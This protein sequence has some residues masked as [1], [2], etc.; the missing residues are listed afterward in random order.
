M[1]R[2]ERGQAIIEFAIVLPM[3]FLLIFGSIDIYFALIAKGT[4]NYVAEET[5]VCV[6][7][8][9]AACPDPQAYAE[10]IGG[11]LGLNGGALQVTQTS[12]GPKSNT[13]T[14]V[15]RYSAVTKFIPSITMTAVAT[16][17]Q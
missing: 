13:I 17:T 10:Q 16:A 1:K 11:G 6:S 8:N 12:S 3:F 4:L 14:A 9:P 2:G 15:Y 7:R 5:A